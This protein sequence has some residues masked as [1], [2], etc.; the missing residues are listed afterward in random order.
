V[1]NSKDLFSFASALGILTF[2]ILACGGSGTT[3]PNTAGPAKETNTMSTPAATPADTAASIAGDYAV[4][5]S[6]PDGKGQYNGDLRVTPRDDVYQFSWVSGGETS[7][8][9][10]VVTG[11][12]VAVAFT[13]GTDGRGCGVVLYQVLENGDLDGKAGYWGVNSF[14][15]ETAKR[16]SG[17]DHL[18][19]YEVSGTNTDGAGYKGTLKI[20]EDGE[21]YSFEWNTGS[22]VK[23]FGIQQNET[24]TAGIGGPQCA[25]VSYEIKPDG[26]LEGKWGGQSTKTFGTETAKKK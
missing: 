3:T 9:V 11:K 20:K 8:G 13:R 4:T 14:E 10:G 24:A 1:K 19:N 23:G 18:V 7:D 25:F 6:N 15:T 21:G 5:G 2:F 17:D 26:T 16:I 22:V 12:K